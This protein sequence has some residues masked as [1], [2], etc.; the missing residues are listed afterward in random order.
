MTKKEMASHKQNRNIENQGNNSNY[1]LEQ[2]EGSLNL[3]LWNQ[4]E[5]V[6]NGQG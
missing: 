4:H 3:E 5:S 6:Q 2:E 1:V